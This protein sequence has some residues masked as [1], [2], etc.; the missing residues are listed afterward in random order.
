MPLQI[1]ANSQRQEGTYQGCQLPLPQILPS[2]RMDG[3]HLH[4]KK[5][6]GF[7][8]CLLES[9]E[10]D[11]YF[12][13]ENK[14]QQWEDIFLAKKLFHYHIKMRKWRKR[15][16]IKGL[17]QQNDDG[18]SYVLFIAKTYWHLKSI[19]IHQQNQITPWIYCTY[20]RQP[21]LVAC[22]E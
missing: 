12:L 18:P 17:C 15:V 11:Q 16:N 14:H 13:L 20:G 8:C 1:W 3:L 21:Q 9:L 7:S 6:N 5:L 19:H 22:G 4:W 10:E 2:Q